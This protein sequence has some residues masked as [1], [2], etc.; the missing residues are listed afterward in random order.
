MEFLKT[1]EAWT[2][3]S[4]KV[5]ETWKKGRSIIVTLSIKAFTSGETV[6]FNVYQIYVVKSRAIW[7]WS[8][9]KAHKV[10][11]LLGYR[12]LASFSSGDSLFWIMCL[13]ILLIFL[14][15]SVNY[16][17]IIRTSVLFFWINWYFSA[18]LIILGIMGLL[19][20]LGGKR[21]SCKAGDAG[22]TGSIAG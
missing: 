7:M 5:N 14:L 10:S 21:S 3:P 11:I 17:C 4:K 6:K 16:L 8:L 13:F 9:Q 20:W 18:L 22:N 2:F 12:I 19:W 1:K 15:H